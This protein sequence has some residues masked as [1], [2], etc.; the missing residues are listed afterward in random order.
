MLLR[1]LNVVGV[2]RISAFFG[3]AFVFCVLSLNANAQST[4]RTSLRNSI[5]R[6]GT[7]K[8]YPATGLMTGCGNLFVY[9]AAPADSSPPEAYVFLSRSDGGNAWMNLSGRDMRLRKVRSPANHRRHADS[10]YYRVGA[11]RISV[12]I[13]SFTPRDGV[14]SDTDMTFKMKITLR[15]GSAVRV[16]RA[17]GSSDC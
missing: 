12:L 11:L 9:P 15:K 4:Q 8:D 1:F 17:I 16:V 5:P 13:E 2:I 7:I 3:C 14:A 6:V 10:Y